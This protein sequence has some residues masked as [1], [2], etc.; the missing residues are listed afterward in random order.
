ITMAVEQWSA[1]STAQPAAGPSELRDDRLRLMFIC[2]HPDISLPSQIALALKTLCGLSPQ[3][4]AQAFLTTEVA[5]EK[6]LTRARQKIR[7]L[8]LPFE[9]PP[10][11]ELPARLDAVLQT[12]YLLFNEGYK[13]STGSAL[14]RA[15]LSAEAVRLV[16]LLLQN[17]L[18]AHAKVHALLALL[19]FNSARFRARSDSAGNLLRLKDQ[20]RRLW[21]KRLTQ[22]G[23][24]HL[25]QSAQGDE[26][27]S[28]H[29]QAAIAACHNTAADH[30]STDWER[31]L[32]LYDRLT[33]LDNS[34]IILLNRAVALAQVQGPAAGLADLERVQSNP[35][36]RAYYLFHA[37]LAELASQLGRFGAA[38]K[39]FQT[40][41][42]LSSL[43]SE[44]AFLA[45]RLREVE[46]RKQNSAF[47]VR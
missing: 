3:E 27:S 2:C 9:L 22:A 41:L 19:L 45:A 28:Y 43:P 20:D 25:E 16:N 38:A 26:I 42:S 14:V 1:D 39:H 24:F 32:F 7:E 4:I 21:D 30:E 29:L 44:R 36:L 15:D 23:I 35:T 12:I 10:G 8:N 33:Q 47:P 13:A 18:T 37:V 11:E 5:I 6:R 40:A 46:S 34:P 17:P 31:I